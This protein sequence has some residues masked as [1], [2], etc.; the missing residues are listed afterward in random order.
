[1]HYRAISADNH[2]NEPG[3]IYVKRVP[4]ALKDRAPRLVPTP[5]GGEAWLVN[6]VMPTK[7]ISSFNGIVRLKGR[8]WKPEDY[9]RFP[10]KHS[11]APAG[12]YVPRIAIEEMEKDGVDASV[13]YP[14]LDTAMYGTRDKVLRLALMRSE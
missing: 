2:F 3:D 11:D 7:G 13:W 4:A 1:M 14:G 6:G 12:S 9:A 10:I 5:D 8:L